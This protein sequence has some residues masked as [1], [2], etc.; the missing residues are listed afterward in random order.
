MLVGVLV[1]GSPAGAAEPAAPG[2]TFYL[3]PHGS[4][5]AGGT[6][7]GAAW[8]TL[9]R[10][11]EV[12]Y[13]PGDRLLLRSGGTFRGTL[14][15]GGTGTAAAPV[16]IS[17]YGKGPRPVVTAGRCVQVEAPF[18]TVTGLSAS[19]CRVSGVRLAAAHGTVAGVT[20]THNRTGVEIGPGATGSQV[21]HSRF[22]NND[23]MRPHTPGPDDDSGANG[24]VVYGDGVTIAHNYFRGQSAPSPDYGRDGSAVEVYGAHG[25]DVHHN[26]SVGDVTFTE[27]GSA[28]TAGARFAYNVVRSSLRTSSFLITRGEGDS[29]GPVYGTVASHNSV[30]LT[31]ARSQAFW[32]G[33]TCGPHVLDLHANVIAASGIGFARGPGLGPVQLTGAGGG[34]NVYQGSVSFELSPGDLVADPLFR[35]ASD[36]RLRPGSPAVDHGDLSSPS[37]DPRAASDY[38]PVDGDGDGIPVADAGAYELVP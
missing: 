2:R 23:R 25:V 21:V 20:T 15:I 1:A 35:S 36:L 3:S 32:C 17:S 11:S 24:I 27:L 28:G 9:E 4:D 6:S 37:P 22:V 18:V 30:A 13:R 29:F 19:G 5:D 33:G 7:A 38:V 31:G 34:D 14:T 16:R 10:A 12:T 8:R 26:T